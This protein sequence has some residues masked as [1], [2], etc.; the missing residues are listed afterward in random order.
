MERGCKWLSHLALWRHTWV[1]ALVLL[2]G[3]APVLEPRPPV[4]AQLRREQQLPEL[5]PQQ[6]AQRPL[7]PPW[8]KSLSPQQQLEELA[9]G[10]LRLSGERLRRAGLQP[11]PAA[12][13]R[14]LR[15]LLQAR[16]SGR[17]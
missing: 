13:G 8:L 6:P 2:L 10:L 1:W 9:L 17:H 4:P 3:R 16:L 5:L 14:Q 12:E 7:M 15:P 11:R